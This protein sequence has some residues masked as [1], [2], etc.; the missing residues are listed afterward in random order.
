MTWLLDEVQWVAGWDGFAR[1]MLDTEQALTCSAICKTFT[2]MTSL[3]IRLSE[4]LGA[5]LETASKARG[6]SKSD[7]AR[8]AIERHLRQETLRGIRQNLAPYF[9]AQGVH[10]EEDVLDRLGSS[11]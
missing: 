2:Y 1:R 7:L 9:E 8:E 3:T 11:L 5:Q 10:T 6:V 4:S